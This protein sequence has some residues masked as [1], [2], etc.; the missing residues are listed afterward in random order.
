MDIVGRLNFHELNLIL[1][2]Q[3]KELFKDFESNSVLL[4]SGILIT[5]AFIFKL[6]AAPYIVGLQMFIKRLLWK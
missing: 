2:S 6:S 3:N 5:S 1:S 4:L